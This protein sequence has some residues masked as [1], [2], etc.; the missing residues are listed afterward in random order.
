MSTR[1]KEAQMCGCGEDYGHH[2]R[3]VMGVRNVC[4]NQ[5]LAT[6]TPVRPEVGERMPEAVTPTSDVALSEPPPTA[7][8]QPTTQKQ[9][10][11]RTLNDYRDEVHA[12]QQKW[13]VDHTGASLHRNKGELIALMHSELSEAMEGERK[14]LMDDKLPHRRMAEVEMAD[15]LIRI[16]DYCGAF[17]YDLEGAYREKTAYNASR[18]DH[19][20]EA[21]NIAAG[22]GF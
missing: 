22:N 6:F 11:S 8:T 10:M 1:E 14:S 21:E 4:P 2:L 18:L 3:S 19:K 7:D 13:W 12:S 5:T 16:F 15:T 17:G 9:T 20:R